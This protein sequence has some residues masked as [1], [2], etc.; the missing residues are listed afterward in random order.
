MFIVSDNYAI[1]LEKICFTKNSST[2]EAI[3]YF[4][5]FEG[6]ITIEIREPIDKISDDTKNLISRIEDYIEKNLYQ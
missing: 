6:P 2:N 1:N 4:I 3:I 5:Y